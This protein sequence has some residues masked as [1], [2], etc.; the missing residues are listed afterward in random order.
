MAIFR[1]RVT[2]AAAAVNTNLLAGSKFEFLGRP[3]AVT[4]WG[5]DDGTGAALVDFTLGNTVIGEEMPLN[6]APVAGDINRDRDGIGAGV[7]DAGDRIQ[8]KARNTSAA[9]PVNVNILLEIQELA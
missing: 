3:S 6:D 7:G 9:N 4:L 5:S 8:I 2:L 1:T